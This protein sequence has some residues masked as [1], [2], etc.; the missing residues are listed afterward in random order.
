[1]GSATLVPSLAGRT[2][3]E[4]LA[5]AWLTTIQSPRTRSEYAILLRRW[6]T[7]LGPPWT[8]SRALVHAFAW[9]PGPR[10]PI[11]GA[12][13]VLMRLSV[14]GGF[15]RFAIVMGA[16]VEGGDPTLGVPR[17]Q[18]QAAVPRSIS[19]DQLRALLK[20]IP[21]TPAGERHRALFVTAIETGL[22]RAEILSLTAQSFEHRNGRTWY[23]VAVKGG[24]FRRRRLPLHAQAKIERMLH[25]RGRARLEALEPEDRIFDLRE[26][27]YRKA[28]RRYAMAVGIGHLVPHQ[29]RH[30]AARLLRER[31]A[32]LEDIM[33]FLGHRRLSTTS[34]YLLR[35][36]GEEEPLCDAVGEDLALDEEDDP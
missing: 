9:G 18:V 17:P 25:A 13:T 5:A 23:T 8:P 20:A 26:R 10:R 24:R 6:L 31:G 36:E 1:M 30:T 11:P 33:R 35:T 19:R 15:Y 3:W 16:P 29:L 27:A 21:R 7:W 2:T 14:L 32:S 12:S 22:R 4:H 34:N 28:L